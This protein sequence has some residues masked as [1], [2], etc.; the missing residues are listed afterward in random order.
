MYSCQETGDFRV[1]KNPQD[2][3]NCHK[4]HNVFRVEMREGSEG[5][6]EVITCAE[7]LDSWAKIASQFVAVI[8]ND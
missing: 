1:T 7:C 4:E 2:C 3:D 8:E 6:Y 5:M